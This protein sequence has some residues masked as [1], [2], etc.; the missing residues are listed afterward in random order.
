[1]PVALERADLRLVHAAWQPAA[2][3]ELSAAPPGET[4]AG[5]YE[6]HARQSDSK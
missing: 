3:A 6:R 2:I 1:L 5:F 4:L